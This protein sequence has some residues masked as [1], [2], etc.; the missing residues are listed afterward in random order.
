MVEKRQNFLLSPG[1]RY[2][3]GAGK[4]L[5]ADAPVAAFHFLDDH[6]GYRAHVL[7]FEID[8][9]IGYASISGSENE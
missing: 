8:H 3:V 9:D 5:A 1:Q 4:S 7:A 2:N 6:H